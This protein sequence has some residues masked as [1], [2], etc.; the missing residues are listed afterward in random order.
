MG[1]FDERLNN[2]E[3][4]T[5]SRCS[6]AMVVEAVEFKFKT[7]CITKKYGLTDNNDLAM[8]LEWAIENMT[9][10]GAQTNKY[11]Y[12]CISSNN[13]CSTVSGGGYLCNCFDG[14]EGNPYLHGRLPRFFFLT[15]DS[16]FIFDV[17]IFNIVTYSCRHQRF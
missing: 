7:T 10:E 2:S 9:C 13:I 12:A 6:Y 8:V 16:F 11:S 15:L 4:K 14:Y 3:V 1:T 17:D 5:F